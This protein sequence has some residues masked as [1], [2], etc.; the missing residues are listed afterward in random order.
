MSE[1]LGAALPGVGG[2][3]GARPP[4]TILQFGT[5]VFLLGF[6]DWLFEQL[7]R[8]TGFDGGVVAL[9]ARPGNSAQLAP[10]NR[11]DGRFYVQLQGLRDGELVDQLDTVDC[12]RR[13]INPFE[14]Y[15]DTRELMVSPTLRFVV[16][17]T[18]EAGIVYREQAA[19][20]ESM[21]QTFPALLT[22][23]LYERYIALAG[24]GD[25]GSLSILCCE[26][27]EHNASRLAE[28]VQRH[29]ADWEYPAGFDAWLEQ[30]VDFCNT[31]VD[32]IVPGSSSRH[33]AGDGSGEEHLV[34]EA[35]A[36]YAWVI[37]APEHV[38]KQLPFEQAGL[39]VQ[40]VDDLDPYR[41]RKVRILNGSHTATFALS[42]MLGVPTVYEA[43]QHPLLGRFLQSLIYCEVC[44]TLAGS[45]EENRQYAASILE[46]FQNPYLEHRWEN[47]ALNAVSKWRARLLPTLLDYH[48]SRGSWPD[49]IVA[50]LAAL[51]LFYRGPWRGQDLPVQDDPAIIALIQRCWS[52]AED[53]ATAIRALL[54]QEELWGQDLSAQPGLSEALCD[55]VAALEADPAQALGS[56]LDPPERD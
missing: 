43:T 33:V 15:S 11:H 53:N 31:L 14:A 55:S 19:P 30:N 5:G 41:E 46:R 24:E 45:A 37:E 22:A 48:A 18:T 35:E 9:K 17:N 7:N 12:L 56:L 29:A 20:S 32:R 6:V 50:S 27:I 3:T 54:S 2:E 25:G 38:R 4:E 40:F 21:P 52:E 23:L 13:A 10:L 16:S 28:L 39:D 1:A 26:L 42:L 8:N 36:F 51:L 34:V 49:L 44:S 47:I